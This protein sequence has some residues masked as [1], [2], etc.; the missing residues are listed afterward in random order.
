[1]HT[2]VPQ[3]AHSWSQPLGRD[4]DSGNF[5][6]DSNK[7]KDDRMGGWGM[8]THLFIYII[9]ILYNK[10]IC[11]YVIYTILI[12]PNGIIFHCFTH[13]DFP[14]IRDFPFLS[15]LLG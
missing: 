7:N 14:E 6:S 5:G 11:I 3:V 12:W 2:N 9:Y 1:M 10:Y 15:Y 4:E 13:L 8:L